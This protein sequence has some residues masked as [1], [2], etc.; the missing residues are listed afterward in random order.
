MF[1]FLKMI[2]TLNRMQKLQNLPM[3]HALPTREPPPPTL[4]SSKPLLIRRRPL[5][6]RPL[7]RRPMNKKP[8]RKR[9]PLKR[10]RRKSKRMTERGR[11]GPAIVLIP[12]PSPVLIIAHRWS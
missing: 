11:G 9:R 5:K 7:K 3:M 10:R 4:P 2:Q 6:K 12:S 8:K 1:K